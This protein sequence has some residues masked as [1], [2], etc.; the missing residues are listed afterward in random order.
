VC[1]C[2]CVYVCLCV[3]VYARERGVMCGWKEETL[4]HYDFKGDET[5]QGLAC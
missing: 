1:V 5:L 4:T 3:C 2:V